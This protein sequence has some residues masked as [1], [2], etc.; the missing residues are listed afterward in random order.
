MTLF[1]TSRR[2]PAAATARLL[3]AV[4]VAW[5]NM[6]VAPCAMAFGGEPD[7]PHCPPAQESEA[8]AH[9]GDHG[10]DVKAGCDSLQSQ[11]DDADQF[12][13]DGRN[14]NNTAKAKVDL[15]LGIPV[16]VPELCIERT[17]FMSSAVDPPPLDATSPPLHI[18]YCVFLD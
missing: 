2:R 8:A 1:A 18:L 11:C 16:L 3:G 12:S 13:F 4:I 5:V 17:A 6:A 7:C 14:T 15:P 9:H 10:D